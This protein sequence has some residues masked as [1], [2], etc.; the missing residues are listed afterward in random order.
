MKR[1][2]P[3]LWAA[4]LGCLAALALFSCS[5]GLLKDPRLYN[6]KKDAGGG[7]GTGRG[8]GA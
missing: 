6:A 5:N 1:T 3:M 2:K 7:G 4:A 8:P